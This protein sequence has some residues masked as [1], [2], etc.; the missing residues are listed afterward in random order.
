MYQ[1]ANR[2]R[3]Q[4]ELP[5]HSPEIG[6]FSTAYGRRKGV[7][8]DR[9]L[10]TFS[11]ALGVLPD[12]RY[13]RNFYTYF[14]DER[15]NLFVQLILG[16]DM[17]FLKA[18]IS[19]ARQNFSTVAQGVAKIENIRH[20]LQDHQFVPENVFHG[21]TRN[22]ALLAL[23]HSLHTTNTEIGQ[24]SFRIDHDEVIS[25]FISAAESYGN[26]VSNPEIATHSALYATVFA[27]KQL[28]R[29]NL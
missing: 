28:A 11:F 26:T 5:R 10:V 19:I 20:A 12:V 22:M 13:K 7:I 21:M 2:P 23:S 25:P 6:I 17:G 29:P 9:G 18:E 24:N 14:D 15:K 27:G 8:T 4:K 3:K 1:N 16:P